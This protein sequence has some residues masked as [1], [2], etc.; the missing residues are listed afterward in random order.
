MK[1]K[2]MIDTVL[3]EPFWTQVKT[4]SKSD[5]TL[6]RV[7]DF[8]KLQKVEKRYQFLADTTK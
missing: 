7:I 8:L 2:N 6:Q 1:S 3:K 4:L 5:T